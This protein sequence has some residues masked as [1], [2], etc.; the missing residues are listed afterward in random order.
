VLFENGRYR[1]WC[2]RGALAREGITLADSADGVHFNDPEI[3]FSANPA[4]GCHHLPWVYIEIL[5]VRRET[6]R[7]ACAGR[8]LRAVVVRRSG[9]A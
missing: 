4:S 3:V 6:T 2:G 7:G 5:L 1:L 9:G 8:D